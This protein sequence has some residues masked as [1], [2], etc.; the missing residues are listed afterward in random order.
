MIKEYNT[1]IQKLFLEMM[2][3][4]AQSF[5]R[6]QNIYNDENFDRS[7]RSVAKFVK[8]HSDKH[9]T[10]PTLEQVRAVTG[11]ELRSIPDLGDG[12]FDWFMEEFESFTKQKE[13]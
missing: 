4:D 9:K 2:L 13:L 10:L 6:V 12:H 8:E 7:L 5:V 3:H 11:V 1:E